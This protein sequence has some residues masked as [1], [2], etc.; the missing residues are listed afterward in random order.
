VEVKAG[1]KL[2]EVGVIP[3]EWLISPLGSFVTE[4]RGGAPLR[5]SDFTRFGTKVL[6]KGGVG[7]SGKLQI[8]ERDVQYCSDEYAKT[9]PRNQVDKSYTIVVLRDLVPSGPSI[10]LMVA[11]ESGDRFVLAQGVYG[12][13]VDTE[14]V[15]PRYLIQL[16][17]TAW[18][19]SLANSIMVGS[20]QVHIT[21]TAYKKAAIPLPPIGEQRAIAAALHSANSTISELTNVIAKKRDV[22]QAVAQQL[23]TGQ[24]RLPGFGGEWVIRRLDAMAD[25]RSGGTPST[26]QS[27]FWN[28]DIP[29]CTPTDITSLAGEKYISRTSRSITNQGLKASSGELIPVGSVVMTSRATIGECA[30]NVVPLSTNQGFKNFVAFPEVDAEFLYYLLQTQ[31]QAFVGLSSGSTF[32]EI[33]KAQLASFEVI[34]PATKIEQAAIASV[35]SDMDVELATFQARRDKSRL[36]AQGMMQELLTGRT[37]LI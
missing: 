7:R 20:T 9:H 5:P 17:N 28:G 22:K 35:L 36:V 25:I 11:I 21:N 3:A 16:S 29:W 8:A 26:T 18:Y 2:T 27:A 1:Y 19:R 32:L 31:R 37:R 15:D 23:L 24:T 30:I 14:R 33:G 34:V 13:K 12:F 6:P 10:G 4:F